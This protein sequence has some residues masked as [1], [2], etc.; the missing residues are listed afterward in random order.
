MLQAAIPFFGVV[1]NGRPNEVKNTFLAAMSRG[2]VFLCTPSRCQHVALVGEGG[3]NRGGGL[4][5]PYLVYMQCLQLF[6]NRH[7]SKHDIQENVSSAAKEASEVRA[8]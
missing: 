7:L 6:R 1:K 4:L 3:E 5:P 2:A 8:N